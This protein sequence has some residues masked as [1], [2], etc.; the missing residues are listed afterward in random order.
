MIAGKRAQ[1]VAK[2]REQVGTVEGPRDN[3]TIYGKFTGHNFQPWCGSLPMWAAHEVGYKEVENVVSTVAG[4]NS[5][6]AKGKWHDAETA[7]PEPGWFAFMG[8][9]PRNPKAI[10]HVETVVKD[11]GDGT[12]VFVGGNTSS[13][14]KGSQANGGEVC[15]TVRAYKKKNGSKFRRSMPVFIIGFGQNDEQISK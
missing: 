11:N 5:Y 3:E 13:G 12:A 15:L 8:F 7:A 6:K 4:A 14:K 1:F 10:Q 2:L 9:D